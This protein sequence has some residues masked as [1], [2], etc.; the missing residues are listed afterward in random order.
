MAAITLKA[1]WKLTVS[2]AGEGSINDSQCTAGPRTAS[3]ATPVTSRVIRLPSGTRR[4]ATSD[5]DC[6]M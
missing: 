2:R 5:P 3:S 4:A 6:A 1:V